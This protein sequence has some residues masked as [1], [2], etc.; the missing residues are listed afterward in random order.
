MSIARTSPLESL[1]SDWLS[2]VDA[3]K[4]AEDGR[5]EAED[6]ATRL[7]AEND[8]LRDQ[9]SQANS[10]RKLWQA[11]AVA[12]DAKLEVCANV[13]DSARNDARIHASQK[14]TEDVP[15]ER[16]YRPEERKAYQAPPQARETPIQRQPSLARP[17]PEP[18]AEPQPVPPRP[19]AR[20]VTPTPPA[21]D[22]DFEFQNGLPR[23]RLPQNQF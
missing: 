5:R 4:F 6:H 16:S 11:Y 18:Q 20:P 8:I 2:L 14:A 23:T 22:A 17:V 3:L 12:V 9:L 19:L 13:I 7:L 1:Q 21:D 15:A 10:E